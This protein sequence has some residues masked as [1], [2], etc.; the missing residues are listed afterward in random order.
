MMTEDKAFQ[1]LDESIG[2]DYVID[3]Y[4]G[5]D[6]WEF[7]TSTGGDVCRYRVHSDG[8]IGAK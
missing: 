2:V 5:R 1:I 4:E 7:I 6:Y 8:S 3:S